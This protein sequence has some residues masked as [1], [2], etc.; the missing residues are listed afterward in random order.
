M[1]AE[2][3]SETLTNYKISQWH[4]PEDYTLHFQT[5]RICTSNLHGRELQF[6][7]IL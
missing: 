7:H 5:S 3:Y 6:H 4:N 1:K 2:V